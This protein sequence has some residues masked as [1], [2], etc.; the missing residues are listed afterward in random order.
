MKRNEARQ[1]IRECLNEIF[2][3][4]DDPDA[5][6][7]SKGERIVGRLTSY[8]VKVEKWNIYKYDENSVVIQ[9]YFKLI[10]QKEIINLLGLIKMYYTGIRMYSDKNLIC[11]E[12]RIA[13]RMI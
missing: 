13:E 3:L 9:L 7:K 8:G 5:K 6:L 10:K 4:Q 12:L 11:V 1:L 2:K